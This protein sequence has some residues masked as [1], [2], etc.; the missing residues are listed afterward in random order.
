MSDTA[1]RS[2]TSSSDLLDAPSPPPDG[3]YGWLVV[4]GVFLA[5]FT[6][7]GYV[8]A[9][10]VLQD[11][12]YTDVFNGQ[13]DVTVF[14]ITGSLYNVMMLL[15]GL[16]LRV[17]L[18]KFGVRGVVAIGACVMVACFIGASFAREPWQ[19]VLTLGAVLGTGAGMIY[20][21]TISLISQYFTRN[22]ALAMGIASAGAGLGGMAFAPAMRA[23]ID[24]LGHER[25]LLIMA[26]VF[27]ATLAVVVALCKERTSLSAVDKPP[28]LEGSGVLAKLFNP[29]IVKRKD[30]QA[31]TAVAFIYAFGVSAPY[32]FLPSY[33]VSIGCTPLQGALAVGVM[34]GV[35]VVGKIILGYV[36]DRIGRINMF[37]ATAFLSGL[38]CIAVWPFATTFGWLVVFAILFGATSGTTDSLFVSVTMDCSTTEDVSETMGIVFSASIFGDLFGAT[39]FAALWSATSSYLAGQIFCAAAYILGSAFI[40]RVRLLKP[41]IILS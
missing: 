39:I 17:P 19:I 31:M 20:N 5:F 16:F 9:W 33:A 36:A 13:V 24:S 32:F 41:P 29:R 2:A 10:G 15:T 28:E 34:S 4:L 26:G 14:S 40:L 21:P 1:D 27:A 6:N 37:F 18:R 30:V 22:A 11:Y 38:F 3:G 8:Q 12:Y 23:L 25:M 7:C 35:N